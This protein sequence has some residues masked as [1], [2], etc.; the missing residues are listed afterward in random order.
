MRKACFVCFL[1]ALATLSGCYIPGDGIVCDGNC[2][3]GYGVK[4]WPDGTYEKGNWRDGQLYGF[5]VQFF[6]TK[7][8]FAGDRYVGN[9]D[10]GYH[11]YGV[12]YGKKLDFVYKGNWLNWKTEGHGFAKFGPNAACPGWQYDG[13]Y[14]QGKKSGYGVAYMGTRGPHAGITY[15]GSWFDDGMLGNGKYYWPDGS[16]YE[17]S[18][19]NG[20]FDGNGTLIFN[21]GAKYVGV[22][23]HGTSATFLK[24][25][26]WHST[27]AKN[28]DTVLMKYF[29][30][31]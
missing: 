16:R 27:V 10:N 6:G 11:G 3:N 21:D 15:A 8:E 26:R 22:W 20:V 19:S 28:R 7:S 12:Y 31:N 23:T 25:L 1:L 29:N 14:K 13:E 4:S 24:V 9:F 18:F 5:G 30:E 17:G 2:T